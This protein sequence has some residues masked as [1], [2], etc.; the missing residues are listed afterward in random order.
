MN[1]E[2]IIS[3]MTLEDKIALCEGA[4]F[5]ETKAYEK[6]GI[7]AMFVCD[8]PS[9]LRRQDLSGGTDM[10]GVNASRP[11]ACFPAGVTIANSWDPDLMQLVGSAIGEEARSQGVCVV[12]G[13]GANL[14]RNPLCGRNFEYLSEDPYLTGKMAAGFIRGVESQVIGSSLKHFA[15]NS[16]ELSRFTSDSI[17]DER[18]LRELYLTGFE[19]AV[20]EGHPSTVMCAYPKLNGVHLSDNKEL[21][22]DILRA[23]WGFDGMV[24]TDWGAMNDRIEGFLA[25]CDLN[26]PGG[27]DY[28][29]KACAQAVKAG[30][31]DETAIDNSVRRILRQVFRAV[32]TLKTPCECDYDAHHAVAR[33]AAEQGAVLLKN[34]DGILPLKKDTKIAVIGAMAKKMRYQGAGS[35]HAR[36][37]VDTLQTVRRLRSLG[38]EVRFEKEGINTLDESGELMITLFASFAQE[39]SRS[40]SENCKW[41]IRKRFQNGTIGVANK[42]ILGYRY[43]NDLQ[44]YIVIPEEAEI[45]RRMFAL[46]LE[47]DSLRIICDK[48]NAQGFRTIN[49]KLFQEASLAQMIQNELYAGDMCRQK[50]YMA[51]PIAKRKTRN[52]GVLPR[53]YY[54]DCHEAIIDR[55]TWELVQEEYERRRE[56][57]NSTYCFTRMITCGLCGMPYTRRR[58]YK[59]DAGHNRWFTAETAAAD[60]APRSG[61]PTTSTAKSSGS[62]TASTPAR[63]AVRRI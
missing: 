61:M 29:A 5:W 34:E 31:L 21:L 45:V 51:D 11:A 55:E 42:H 57:L 3:E 8:G 48:L 47:G 28:M 7:P 6:Y 18:T 53:F 39:E 38:V 32:V 41:G 50:S 23:E 62:A 20:K 36:N 63:S 59:K 10:L 12:L 43:D 2:K 26:M 49:D 54:Q 4:N 24:I 58:Q 15:A 37:T 60:T 56:K 27:S 1:I 33:Q 19:I 22:T 17:M 16:Q 35:S 13:P 30:I 44:K 52:D 14:K 40:I 25:G 46:F 9:G